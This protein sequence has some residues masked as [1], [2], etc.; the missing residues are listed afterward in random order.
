MEFGKSQKGG[1]ILF[2]DGFKYRVDK[3]REGYTTWQCSRST[4]KGRLMVIT[5]KD[6]PNRTTGHN[7]APDHV[8]KV[9]SSVKENIRELARTTDANPR[10]IVQQ[11]CSNSI[12]SEEAAVNLPSY[13]ASRKTIQRIRNKEY[14]KSSIF[15]SIAEVRIEGQYAKT[16]RNEEFLLYDSG[17]NNKNR[18]LI[19]GTQNN[20]DL[21]KEFT[22]WSVDGTFKACP[23]VFYQLFVIHALI[24]SKALPMLYALLPNKLQN[25]YVELFESLKTLDQALEPVSVIVDLEQASINAIMHVFPNSRIAGCA[26]HLAQNLWRRIQRNGLTQLY[27][28]NEEIRLLCKMLLGLSYVPERDVQFAM[29]IISQEVPAQLKP[30][31]QYWED[32]YVGRRM[33]NIKARFDI[34]TW[35]AFERVNSDLPKTNNS[36]EAWHHS[37]QRSLNCQHPHIYKLLNQLKKEQNSVEIFISRHRAG[38]RKKDIPN[39][40][41]VQK[42]KR[43]KTLVATYS[44]PRVYQYLKSIAF[45]LSL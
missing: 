41:Y 19:F 8:D 30:I 43:L 9:I 40:K 17:S 33:N 7:H 28:D 20:L 3:K 44:F 26:F 45:N 29:E 15:N 10:A 31:F 5:G 6:T 36:L 4:Y 14:K 1:N 13:E 22:H 34:S 38:F 11:A 2:Y 23:E 12:S 25:T 39:S 32:N 35:N 27:T 21:L 16:D 42:N 24:D 37:L 18:I